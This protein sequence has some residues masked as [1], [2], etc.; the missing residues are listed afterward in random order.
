MALKGGQSK[1]N[2]SLEYREEIV[3]RKEMEIF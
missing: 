3:R 2:E 1:R